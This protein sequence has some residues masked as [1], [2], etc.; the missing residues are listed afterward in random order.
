MESGTSDERPEL[1]FADGLI[2]PPPP[3]T[4]FPPAHRP[5]WVA[6]GHVVCR[7]CHWETRN[8]TAEFGSPSEAARSHMVDMGDPVRCS[9]CDLPDVF[10]S[11]DL[12][13][14]RDGIVVWPPFAIWVVTLH[15][16]GKWR[17]VSLCVDCAMSTLRHGLED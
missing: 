13:G 11:P 10:Y 15:L 2:G 7:D 17:R 12:P 16:P 14:E 9:T 8:A 3:G 4:W 5:L 6:M 1:P